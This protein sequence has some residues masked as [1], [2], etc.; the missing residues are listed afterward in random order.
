MLLELEETY[1]YMNRMEDIHLQLIMDIIGQNIMDAMDLSTG[2]TAN[3]ELLY[4][5]QFHNLFFIIIGVMDEKNEIYQQ[6]LQQIDY[7]SE[8]IEK[9]FEK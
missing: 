7:I 4:S 1:I 3:P 9:E 5:F 6:A 8:L 2:K